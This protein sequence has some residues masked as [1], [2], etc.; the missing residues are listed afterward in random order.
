M[1]GEAAATAT[2]TYDVHRG[3]SWGAVSVLATAGGTF[4][5]SSVRRMLWTVD[6]NSACNCATKP[7]ATLAATSNTRHG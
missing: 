2:V 6:G 4:S 7:G 1:I 5:L 3:Q